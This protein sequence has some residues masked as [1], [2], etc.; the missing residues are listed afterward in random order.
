MEL[1]KFINYILKSNSY[2]SF[3]VSDKQGVNCGPGIIPDKNATQIM[4]L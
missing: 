3:S 1:F 4:I 2:E